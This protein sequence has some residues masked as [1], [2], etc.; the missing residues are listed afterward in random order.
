MPPMGQ[1][2][3]TEVPDNFRDAVCYHFALADL[4]QSELKTLGARVPSRNVRKEL[5]DATVQS[6]VDS[7]MEEISAEYAEEIKNRLAETQSATEAL[8]LE[9]LISVRALGNCPLVVRKT[10]DGVATSDAR[11][12]RANRAFIGAF[13]GTSNSLIRVM[14]PTLATLFT[15]RYDAVAFNPV[16]RVPERGSIVYYERYSVNQAR[17]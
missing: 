15:R 11:T 7:L 14:K 13:A 9:S 3:E 5:S 1:L 8:L 6:G 2:Q 10:R 17:I 12:L 16:E 4:L